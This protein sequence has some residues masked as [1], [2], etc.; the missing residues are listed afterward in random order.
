MTTI[1]GGAATY[2]VEPVTG[3]SIGAKS[4]V[5]ALRFAA[6]LVKAILVM[7][8]TPWI[9]KWIGLDNPRTAMIFGGLMG[10]TS[11]VAGGLEFAISQWGVW[12]AGGVSVPL[13]GSA[14][15]S[16]LESLRGWCRDRLSS[17][18][19]PQASKNGCRVTSQCDG[20][21]C[22]D[23]CQNSVFTSYIKLT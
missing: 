15:A 18:Q 9:A 6:G 10:T 2:I 11:G 16:E 1:G 23:I 12:R 7:V 17:F 3:A 19:N 14:T 22:K 20:E 5:I 8:A 21:N 4:D 13:S